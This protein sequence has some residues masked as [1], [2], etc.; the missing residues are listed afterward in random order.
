MRLRRASAHQRARARVVVSSAAVALA[1]ALTA[2]HVLDG[3]VR[4]AVAAQVPATANPPPPRSASDA[5]PAVQQTYRSTAPPRELGPRWD[6]DGAMATRAP[7]IASYTLHAKLDEDA[8]IVFGSGE[9]RW[10]NTS[11]RAVT[12]VWLHLYLNAFKNEKSLFLR[13]RF[14]GGRSGNR[15]TDFGYMDVKRL[16]LKEGGADLWPSRDRHSPGDADDETDIRVPLPQAVPPGGRLTLLVEFES[17]LPDIVERTGHSGSF[18]MVAQWFPKLARLEPDGRWAHFPFH[19]QAEFYADFGRYDVTLDVP[20]AFHVGATGP[21]VEERTVGDRKI[22]RHVQENV[23][24]FAW[25]AWDRFVERREVIDGVGVHLL[26][27]PEHDTNA[28]ITL[29]S[30]RFALPRLSRRFGRYPYP[31]LTVVHP[32]EAAR[33][34]GGMEYPTLITTG[35]PWWIGRAA[36]AVEAVTV[37]E[38]AHQWFYGL[39]AT[40]EQAWPF[41][42]E[43]LTTYAE[44]SELEARWGPRSLSAFPGVSLSQTAVRR[45]L[46]ASATHS[47]VVAL[48]ARDFA[49]FRQLGGLVYARTGTL[50][51]TLANV[52]GAD[53]VDRALGRYARRYRFDHPAPAH[54][55]AAL[56]EVL[57]DEAAETARHVLYDR[58][59][60]DY[61]VSDVQSVRARTSAGVFDEAGERR[62][63]EHGE[64][65]ETAAW[66]G[67]ILV[68]RHGTLSFPVTIELVAEDGTRTRRTWDGKTR[69][70]SLHHEGPSRLAGAIVDPDWMITLDQ[71]LL[72]NARGP[73]SS[74]RTAERLAYAAGLL[75]SVVGP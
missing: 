64:A 61:T 62:T 58:G 26:Y 35:G 13:S 23:H 49:T 63:V 71:N 66:T 37:H 14:G 28:E 19:A 60:V 69:W 56:R 45:A 73:R 46:A 2:S 24:D 11:S 75:L 36:R 18:H 29:D 34:A 10:T 43:G 52:H 33:N 72:N 4:L 22:V 44:A 12:E 31:V 42:D 50:F 54:L 21:R 70:T 39:V 27:P 1:L 68:E 30:L 51:E 9:L 48:P 8:H 3:A 16:V 15:T 53:A 41:L 25:V 47:D 38:L 55:F 65:R 40:D 74:P 57:G 67:R 7:D 32:P 6:D 20:A 59:W 5:A 17:R